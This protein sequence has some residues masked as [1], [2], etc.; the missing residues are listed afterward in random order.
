M[1]SLRR[2]AHRAQFCRTPM[3]WLSTPSRGGRSRGQTIVIFA[4]SLTVL[5][6]FA[7]L[8]VDVMR[9]YDLYAREQRAAEAGALA[10]V[11][12][13]PCYYNSAGSTCG[14]GSTSPDGNSAAS[15]AMEEV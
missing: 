3:R 8:S 13:L 2:P 9:I 15:R 12:Y 14:D 6:G 1:T 11:M 7:G 4:L 5:L 10:G